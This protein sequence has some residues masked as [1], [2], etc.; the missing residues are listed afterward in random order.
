ML[1]RSVFTFDTSQP[2]REALNDKLRTSLP[3]KIEAS[4]KV[5]FNSEIWAD[6]VGQKTLFVFIFG[7]DSSGN[8]TLYRTQI[9]VFFDSNTK[10]VTIVPVLRLI[11][12]P[13]QDIPLVDFNPDYLQI[14]FDTDFTL[15][16]EVQ[17]IS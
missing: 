12:I 11:D 7:A 10:P 15:N 1:F 17:G 13:A 8:P 3:W 14:P 2:Y 9:E 5:I 16:F 6:F 4:N